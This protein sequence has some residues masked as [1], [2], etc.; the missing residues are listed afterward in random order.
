MVQQEIRDIH[1][2]EILENINLEKFTTI[3]LANRGT[4]IKVF[5][6]AAL[7][8]LIQKLLRDKTQY[9]LI[10]WGANQV[11]LNTENTLFIKLDFS[12]SRETFKAVQNEY[13]LPASVPLNILT[14][15]A[16]KF[17]LKGWE[18]F[19]GIPASLGGAIYMN[20]G[21]SLGEIGSLIKSVRILQKDGEIRIHHCTDQDFSYRKNHFVKEGEVIISAVL[22]HLGQDEDLKTQIQEYLE[23]RKRTQPLKTKN[24]GSVFKNVSPQFRAGRTIDCIGL[25]EFGMENLKVSPLHANFVENSG[26]ASAKDFQNLVSCLKIDMERYSG[27]KFELEVKVY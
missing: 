11:L 1:D 26:E 10:G 3:R 25:K 18:V 12:Y 13:D 16:T 8:A 7:T 20:A 21:T 23:M 17:G 15:H 24:C 9:H 4:V 19:T 2:I 27:L 5:T 14:S 6:E 22:R